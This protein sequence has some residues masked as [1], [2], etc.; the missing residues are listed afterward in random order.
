MWDQFTHFTFFF[1]YVLQNT[2]FIF[3]FLLFFCYTLFPP[4]K[5]FLFFKG[6]TIQTSWDTAA[7]S[8]QSNPTLCSPIDGSPP[9]S[10]VPRI[11]Q[12]R[13]LGKC[14]LKV[15]R[16]FSG[17]PVVKNPS[18][19]CSGSGSEGLIPG[20]ETRIPYAGW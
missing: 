1:L 4:H 3:N 11:L 18:F 5:L 12:A 10:P 6:T 14:N 20:W 9:G 7:E 2:I 16:A 17:G 13:T 8:L 15:I 19:Q